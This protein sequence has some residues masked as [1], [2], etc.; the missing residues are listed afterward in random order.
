MNAHQGFYPPLGLLPHVIICVGGR[1]YKFGILVRKTSKTIF[2]DLVFFIAL[3]QN[4][5][6]KKSNADT[7]TIHES[8]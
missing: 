5:G 7:I 6:G 1:N 4:S 3:W 8:S 2:S